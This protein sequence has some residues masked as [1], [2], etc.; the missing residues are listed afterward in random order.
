[1]CE[2]IDRAVNEGRKEGRKEGNAQ[3]L[4]RLVENFVR[5]SSC[6]VEVACKML[7]CSVQEY[8]DA[9]DMIA[10]ISGK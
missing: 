8:Y 2:V 4:V 1:M 3:T 5:Y 9:K 7:G 10:N 6:S